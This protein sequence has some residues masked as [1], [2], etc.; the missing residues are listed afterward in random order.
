MITIQTQLSFDQ[1]L[2]AVSQLNLT[3]L[4]QFQ[5]QVAQLRA[6][7]HNTSLSEQES[8]LLIKIN[9]TS[10]PQQDAHYQTLLAKRRDKSLTEPEREELIALGDQ[11][12]QQNAERIKHLAQ[13][14]EIKGISVTDLMDQL[15]IFLLHPQ[16]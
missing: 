12:E 14:A 16:S 15:D 13:L 1:L 6:R 4:E 9:S 10:S 5:K 2:D 8:N 7:K 3:E 11:Y